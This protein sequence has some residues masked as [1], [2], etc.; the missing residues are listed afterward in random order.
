MVEITLANI[1]TY[2]SVNRKVETDK[3]TVNYQSLF[4]KAM[5][6]SWSQTP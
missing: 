1:L 2:L 6:L 4:E 5:L 3:R